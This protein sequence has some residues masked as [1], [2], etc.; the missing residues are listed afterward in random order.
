MSSSTDRVAS[1]GIGR[2][3]PSV[4]LALLPTIGLLPLTG[5]LLGLP[6]APLNLR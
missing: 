6:L 4:R 2:R 3:H 1:T 5:L